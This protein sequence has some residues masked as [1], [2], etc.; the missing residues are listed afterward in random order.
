MSSVRIEIKYSK[1][2][3]PDQIAAIE[4]Y[5]SR[6]EGRGVPAILSADHLSLLVGVKTERLYAMSNQPSSFYRTFSVKKRSGGAR[7]ISAPLPLLLFVQRWILSNILEAIPVHEAAKAYVKGG[8]IKKNARLH[9]GQAVLFKSDVKDFFPSIG[10]FRVFRIFRDVGY[11]EPVAKILSGLCCLEG[12]LPQGAATSGQ[13]SNIV[14]RDFDDKL[15]KYCTGRG[16]RYSRYADDITISGSEVESDAIRDLISGGLKEVDLTMNGG[17]TKIRRQHTRQEVTGVV[18]NE[19]LSVGRDYLRR[20]RQEYYFVNKFGV[21]GHTRAIGETSPRYV[22]ER[23]IGQFA[24]AIHI[25][26]KNKDLK[27][28]KEVLLRLRREHFGY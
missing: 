16:L 21:H 19:R 14:M 15:L 5:I 20:L 10:E 12:S 4:A 24:H 25:D 22:L 28:C 1:G 11:L 18:V 9:R 17:K 2:I 23:L 6:L 7:K 27:E 8:S 13:L 3:K 26:T